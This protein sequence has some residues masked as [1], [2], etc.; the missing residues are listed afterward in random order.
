MNI[1]MLRPWVFGTLAIATSGLMQA[2][3]AATITLKSMRFSDAKP[4]PHLHY[5]GEV[6]PGDLKRLAAAVRQHVD[7]DPKILPDTGANCAVLTLDSGGGNY[8]EGLDIAH[9]LRKNAIASWVTNGS[10]CFSACAFAFLGGS[11]YSS[12]RPTGAYIDRTIEPGATLGFHAPF[13]TPDS[14]GDLVARHGVE[15]VLGGNRESIA[16]MIEQLVHWNVDP[17]VL[18]RIADMG[19]Q[20]AFVAAYAQDLYLLRTA[21]PNVPLQV[22]ESS[23]Q[24]ALRNACMRLL[25]YHEQTWPYDTRKQLAGEFKHNIGQDDGGRMLSGYQIV[26]RPGGLTISYCAV[27]TADVDLKSAADI[28]LFFGPG[29][30]GVMRPALTFFSRPEGWSTMATGGRPTQR[31]FQK[32]LIGHFFMA[33]EQALADGP[34]MTW[35]LIG[36]KYLQTGQ[37]GQ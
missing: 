14:L 28:A 8:V 9:F 24:Q 11:G 33:P 31:I 22:W 19:P 21:L 15:E 2:A 29:I 18:S 16:L 26:D 32:G 10:G 12:W 4:V 5:E 37:A 1:S 23:A 6:V 34:A 25:A 27:A 13:F 35:R 7:C 30:E 17:T 36:E 20:D 3:Q